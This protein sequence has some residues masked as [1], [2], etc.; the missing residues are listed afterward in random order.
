RIWAE[1]DVIRD[2]FLKDAKFYTCGGNQIAA[3]VRDACIRIIAEHKGGDE[4]A[5][6]EMWKSI[7]AE[8]YATD[9]FG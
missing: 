8:R 1:R 3:G 2:Y 4:A 7:Q 5:T 9:V 6:A